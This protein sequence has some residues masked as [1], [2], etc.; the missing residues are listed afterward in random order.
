MLVAPTQDL[1]KGNDADLEESGVAM[2][3]DEE[4][5]DDEQEA[6]EGGRQPKKTPPKRATAK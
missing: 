2:E 1:R 3:E 6:E 4:R 5:G